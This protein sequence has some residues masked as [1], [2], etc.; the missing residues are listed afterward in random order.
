MAG[1]V[2]PQYPVFPGYRQPYRQLPPFYKPKQPYWKPPYKG[3]PGPMKPTNPLDCL[4]GYKWAQLKA[5]LSQLG[6]EFGLGRRFTKEVGVQVNPRV[7]A[8]I[9]CSLGPRTL[10][11]CKGGPFLFHAVPGQHA[12]LGII[13]PVRFPRTTAVYSR[14]SDRRLFTLPTPTYGG[15]KEGGTQ[16]DPVE[17]D[18]LLKRPT[19]QFL[20]QK[21]G[22]FQCKDCQIRWESAYVWCV[23]GTNKVYFKQFCHKCQ[24]G[25][26]PYYVE[27]IECKRCKKAW[28][29][30]PER[31][32]IDLKRPHCQDLCG[33]CKGQRLSCDKTFS[34][35][36]II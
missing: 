6:P 7:D 16:M 22:F 36:Y 17:E 24:K 21:Y 1:L 12:G 23:S 2:Y 19:F 15:K 33:R 32:H 5:L 18:L 10:K 34:F 28:C 13:A 4:D 27:S 26:N 20:E 25:H 14:L 8:C 35:K 31:R 11:N 9:Q 30:C 3:V 29:S